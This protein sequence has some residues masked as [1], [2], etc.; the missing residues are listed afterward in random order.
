MRGTKPRGTKPRGTKGLIRSTVRKGTRFDMSPPV[1]RI[2][3]R[4]KEPSI[5][6][7]CAAVYLHKTW[8]RKRRLGPGVLASAKWT[9]CPACRQ[10]KGGDEYYG[11]VLVRGAY[12]AEHEEE[13]RRRIQNVAARAVFNQPEHQIES[14]ESTDK[15][16]E[17]LTTSQKLAHRIAH[18]LEKAFGGRASY[19]WSDEDGTLRAVWQSPARKPPA[20]AP[21][22]L[23]AKAR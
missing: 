6:E 12:A 9:V 16:L 13:I 22:R 8:R 18:E 7:R 23:A 15:T 2:N 21:R 14:I 5:C 1:A 4:F 20:K 11:Q 19:T 10:V 3:I 17:V